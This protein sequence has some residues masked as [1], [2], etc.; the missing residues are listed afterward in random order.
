MST[1][2]NEAGFWLAVI[3]LGGIAFGV[4]VFLK[5]VG[6]SIGL[7]VKQTASLL[8]G[9]AILVGGVGY[10]WLSG[11]QIVIWTLWLLVLAFLF[12]I[13][14]MDHWSLDFT[15]KLALDAGFSGEGT[16]EH[17]W[18]G[19]GWVQA[20]MFVGLCALASFIHYND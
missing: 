6:D 17:A 8:V 20:L 5:S 16:S 3:M 7:P 4:Y 15:S 12:F 19:R 10:A 1:R 14:A 18:Y 11:K 13:P 2:N 9:V